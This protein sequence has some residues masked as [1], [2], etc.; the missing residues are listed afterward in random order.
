MSSE[1]RKPASPGV[2][3]KIE[4]MTC[5][6]QR[7][8]ELSSEQ[9]QELSQSWKIQETCE[10][11]GSLADWT[12]AQAAIEE[13]EQQDFWDWMAVTAEYFQ[14]ETAPQQDE[15]RKEPRHEVRVPLRVSSESGEDEVTS[16]NI[17]RSGFC[18]SSTRTYQVGQS[19]CV[20]LALPGARDPVVRTG[21]IVRAGI[22]ADGQPAYG[23]RLEM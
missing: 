13:T 14:P 23:V 3:V 20:T 21:T 5:H 18:F 17:S 22:G 6:T 4:C 15:R 1:A 16:N 2:T 12:F 11:C 7:E 10:R 9:F 19:I 8:V